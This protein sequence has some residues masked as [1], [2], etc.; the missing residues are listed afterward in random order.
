MTDWIQEVSKINFPARDQVKVILSAP[1]IHLSKLSE[2]ISQLKLPIELASQDISRF[3]EGAYT[4]EITG[5][6][7]SGLVKY[8]L[9]GHSERR[10]YFGEDDKI[11]EEKVN[12]AVEANL[13]V[14]YCVSDPDTY[15]PSGVSNIAYEPVWAIG[16]GKAEAPEETAF[17]IRK[18][19]EKNGN[20]K[21][22]IYGGSVN[23]SNVK[24]FFTV[25]GADG[26][27]PGGASLDPKKFTAIITNAS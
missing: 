13:N 24:S 3:D 2:L 6:M 4:G 12:R 7:L 11:L 9:I 25:S 26:V 20:D 10:K 1:Y 14:I 27:L 16:T 8:V 19:K 21:V 5:K 18:L 15:I 17:I 23:E 22:I